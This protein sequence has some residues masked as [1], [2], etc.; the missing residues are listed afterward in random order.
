[1]D[2][3]RFAVS[4]L[5]GAFAMHAIGYL[6]LMS[7]QQISMPQTPPNGLNQGQQSAVVERS[8]KSLTRNL[9]RAIYRPLRYADCRRR[10]ADRGGGRRSGLVAD[11][12][13]YGYENRWNL[14]LTITHPML[15]AIQMAIAG[16]VIAATHARI[17]AT[18]KA[19]AAA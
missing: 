1:M 16:A 10:H 2:I 5:V 3:K 18:S 12:T 4:V 6:V 8:R 11:F 14:L 9:A 15:A 17:A 19:Q 7:L 13:F